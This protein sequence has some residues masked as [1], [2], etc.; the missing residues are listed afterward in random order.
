[1]KK[2]VFLHPG[3]FC[4]AEAPAK[5]QTILGSCIAFTMRDPVSGKAAMCH[6]LLPTRPMA[7]AGTEE[8]QDDFRYVDSSLD[9]MLNTFRKHNVPVQRLEI[10]LFG[11]ANVLQNMPEKHAVGSLNWQQARQSL[12]AVRL[13]LCAHDIGGQ[14]GRRLLFETA[15]GAVFVRRLSNPLTTSARRVG[16][17]HVKKT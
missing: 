17:H 11:G 1:M 7:P 9:A 14:A 16:K 5:I 6:C 2:Q 4:F 10:K 12:Q 13:D 3:E 8:K 15:T